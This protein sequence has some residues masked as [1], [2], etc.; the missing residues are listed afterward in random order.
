MQ[1]ILTLSALLNVALLGT[2]WLVWQRARAAEVADQAADKQRRKELVDAQQAAEVVRAEY[3]SF[4][5]A[6]SACLK[7]VRRDIDRNYCHVHDGHVLDRLAFEFE[8]ARGPVHLDSTLAAEIRDAGGGEFITDGVMLFSG[9][10]TFAWNM[11]EEA[12]R[13][14]GKVF[15]VVRE[16]CGTTN[17]SLWLSKTLALYERICDHDKGV[18]IRSLSEVME[19]WKHMDVDSAVR[20]VERSLA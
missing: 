14:A 1:V 9:A 13:N 18:A 16:S 19:H 7:E 3:L 2:G 17:R 5:S 20:S 11:H 12:R 15:E 10:L 8:G 4:V 6:V